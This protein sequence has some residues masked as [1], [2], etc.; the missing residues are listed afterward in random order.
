MS[1]IDRFDSNKNASSAFK[2]EFM[3][4]V[5]FDVSLLNNRSIV[6]NITGNVVAP[7]TYTLS[8]LT[9]PLNALYAAGGPSENGSYREVKIIRAGKEVHS[10]DLYNYFAKS[11]ENYAF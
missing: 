5:F 7:G 10:V 9:N 1:A 4:F 6:I 2:N 8:S 11:D 3:T